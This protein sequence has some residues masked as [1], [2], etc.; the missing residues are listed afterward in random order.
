MKVT[1]YIV[2]YLLVSSEID[3]GIIDGDFDIDVI[4]NGVDD[5]VGEWRV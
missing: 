4:I 1:K 2:N 3:N 5:D